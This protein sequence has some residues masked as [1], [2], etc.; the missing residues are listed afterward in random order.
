MRYK[1][2]SFALFILLFLVLCLGYFGYNRGET[3]QAG[4][5]DSAYVEKWKESLVA[6]MNESDIKLIV[7]RENIDLSKYQI[8]INAN[9]ELMIPVPMLTDVFKCRFSLY[10][11]GHAIIEKN[12][13]QIELYI[14]EYTMKVN[15]SNIK[16]SSPMIRNEDI[17][18]IPGTVLEKGLGY[19]YEWDNENNEVVMEN[20]IPFSLP[21]SFDFRTTDQRPSIKDQGEYGT[22]W[23]FAA[24]TALETSIMPT[25]NMEFS[26]DHMTLQNNFILS[27]EDGGDYMMAVAYMTSWTGPVLEEKDPYGDGQTVEGLTADAHIQ[28][29]QMID[30]KDYNK[31]KEAVYLYGG[32]QTSLYSAMTADGQDS[33][34]YNSKTSSYCYHGDEQ[35]NHD[36]VIVGW[37]DEYPK[38]FFN[39]EVEGNGAFLCVNSWGE[40]FGSEGFFYVSYYDD[41]IGTY[42]IAY[43]GIDKTDNYD[44]IYQTDL[45]GWVGQLGFNEESAYFANVYTADSRQTLDAV[46]FYATGSNTEYEVYVINDFEKEKLSNLTT[47][48]KTGSFENSGYYTVSLGESIS[49]AADER[50]AVVVRITTPNQV[51]PIAV[52]Y[53]AGEST[54]S[55]DLTDGEGYIS[56][57]GNVWQNVEKKQNCNVCL[58]A[59]TSNVY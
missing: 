26:V 5:N 36:V 28:E 59:F 11:D 13:I 19:T 29:V 33:E 25:A 8:Y 32:V 35:I 15:G 20:Y 53:V 3:I 22:C 16:L 31:I 58:K 56:L 21:K 4:E 23:A 55:V 24:L 45:C 39:T 38:E 50:F 30:K 52:E 27:Q 47:P 57:Q 18:Y 51:H 37:D 2:I 34:Y 6:K 54:Q 49:L 40:T 44:N 17:V 43:T 7:N 42:N 41:Y 1:R 14:D 46:S 12:G 48:V 10:Q 9:M